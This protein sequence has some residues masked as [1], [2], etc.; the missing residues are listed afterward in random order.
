VIPMHEAVA[1]R[2]AFHHSPAISPI[3]IPP[4]QAVE[5]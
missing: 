5:I 4:A 1:A 2:T 3:W